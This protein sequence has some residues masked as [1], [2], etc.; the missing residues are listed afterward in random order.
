[1]EVS[2]EL[3]EKHIPNKAQAA[4]V[5]KAIPEVADQKK[6]L[7]LTLAELAKRKG[8]GRK[9]LESVAAIQLDLLGK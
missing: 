1:M 4:K 6:F 2:I 9:T 5:Y 7:A 3:F 8:M